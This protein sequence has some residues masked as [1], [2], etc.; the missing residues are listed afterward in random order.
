MGQGFQFQTQLR[1]P[2]GL[3]VVDEDVGLGFGHAIR[4]ALGLD[5]DVILVTEI[6]DL[7]A[8]EACLRAASIERLVLARMHAPD[9]AYG[10][11]RL[12]HMGVSPD[13][14]A[15]GLRA[16]CAQ[17]LV[18]RPCPHCAEDVEPSAQE[19]ESL[20]CAEAIPPDAHVLRA[21]GC[22]AC[23]Q[24]GYAGRTGAFELLLPD[25]DMRGLIAR[26]AGRGELELA[27]RAAGVVTIFE[28]LMR[29]VLDRQTTMAEA[30]RVASA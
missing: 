22:S 2:A 3:N 27:V 11:T 29:K 20:G 30:H 18:R 1:C 4:A 28:S 13:L 12:L 10:I 7:E 8:A 17:V 23:E 21:V 6:R 5:P 24:S 15:S 26:S 9:A 16:V 25:D 14:V 19:R